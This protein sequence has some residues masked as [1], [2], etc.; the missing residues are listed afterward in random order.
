MASLAVS[1]DRLEQ[2]YISC[3]SSR[4]GPRLEIDVAKFFL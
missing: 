1:Y 4:I 3:I 2:E